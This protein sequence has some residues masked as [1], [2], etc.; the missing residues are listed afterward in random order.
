MGQPAWPWSVKAL[1][2]LATRTGRITAGVATFL[3]WLLFVFNVMTVEF[4][5]FHVGGRGWWNQPLIQLPWFDYTPKY[6]R[7]AAKEETR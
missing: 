4:L 5:H 3:V 6:L 2:W 1:A 7:E